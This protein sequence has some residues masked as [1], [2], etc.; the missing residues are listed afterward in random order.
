VTTIEG[1]FNSVASV[2]IKISSQTNTLASCG[3]TIIEEEEFSASSASS[4]S[5]QLNDNH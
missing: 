1:S 3:Y 5:D 2:C 4:K